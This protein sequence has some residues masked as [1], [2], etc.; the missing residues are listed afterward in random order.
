MPEKA[1]PRFEQSYSEVR[2]NKEIDRLVN[3]FLKAK[4]NL[5]K[6]VEAIKKDVN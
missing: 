6:A 3:E 1:I 2:S 5:M 4:S